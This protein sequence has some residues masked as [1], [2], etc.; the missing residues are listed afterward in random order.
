[1]EMAKAL[2]PGCFYTI[3]KLRVV[4]SATNNQ[5]Q[6][7]LGGSE[8][9]IQKLQAKSTSNDKLVALLKQVAITSLTRYK[10]LIFFHIGA[11]SCGNG[12][13]TQELNKI[14]RRKSDKLISQRLILNL[15]TILSETFL[16]MINCPTSFAL[17]PESKIS[18]HCAWR[19]VL[20]CDA[21]NVKKSTWDF[22]W[23]IR[24]EILNHV[25]IASAQVTRNALNAVT[26]LQA[27]LSAYT[28]SSFVWRTRKAKSS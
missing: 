22:M 8:R 23:L 14:D 26:W 21:C 7:R 28:V 16:L 10:L 20:Y 27:P 4:Q 18:I 15:D 3:R 9:L 19:T 25:L 12:T 5:F 13:F 2:E 17:S 6:G 24:P 1:M 11:R